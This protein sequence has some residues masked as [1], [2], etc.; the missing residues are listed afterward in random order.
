MP[1]KTT[2]RNYH[3]RFESLE[4]KQLLSGGLL[5]QEPQAVAQAT[6]SLSSQVEH[7]VARPDGTGHGIV[8]ITS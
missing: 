6:V 1:R 3:P 2:K 5:T 4:N 7:R 8:I